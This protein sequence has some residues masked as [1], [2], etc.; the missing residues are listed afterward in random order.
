MK[1]LVLLTS[2][3]LMLSCASR[4]TNTSKSNSSQSKDSIV[5]VIVDG[6]SVS[7]TN[8]FRDELLLELEIRPV[9]D[10]MP[11]F[12]AGVEYRN[13]ILTSKKQRVKVIDTSKLIVSKK[14][15]KT[16][17]LKQAYS[18]QTKE[19]VVDKKANYFVYLWLL[20]IPGIVI[21]YKAI[22]KVY[23]SK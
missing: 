3:V 4:K 18:I 11:M 6:L 21:V 1:K 22:S 17:R 5:E 2:I 20:L 15:L 8:I 9:V 12:V 23:F 19:K 10:S 7:N 14:T 16:T 13:A